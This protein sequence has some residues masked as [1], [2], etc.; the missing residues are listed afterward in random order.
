MEKSGA[1]ISEPYVLLKQK[2][3]DYVSDTAQKLFSEA[4]K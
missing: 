2:W 4:A 3:V 1:D